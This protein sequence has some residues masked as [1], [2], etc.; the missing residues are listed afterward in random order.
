MVERQSRSDFEAV[1][2]R[3]VAAGTRHGAVVGRS[4]PRVRE[5]DQLGIAE[6]D[7]D[8]AA[9]HHEP[10]DPGTGAAVAHP[11]HEAVAVHMAAGAGVAYHPGGQG[12][13]CAR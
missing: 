12:V 6:A 13:G 7:V 11:Q 3:Q 2:R 4:P 9:V 8:P 1:P 5:A 10:L